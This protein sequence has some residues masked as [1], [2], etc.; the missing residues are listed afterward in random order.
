MKGLL[1]Y[2]PYIILLI[3]TL[4]RTVEN[5]TRKA[6]GEPCDCE[7]QRCICKYFSDCQMQ[8]DRDDIN[9]CNRKQGIV[10]CK[11]PK[12]IFDPPAQLASEF[13]CQKY[14]EMISNDCARE[15]ITGGELARAKEFPPAALVG[16]FNMETKKHDWICGGTLISERFVLTASH[17]AKTGV[18]NRVRLGDLDFS[19]NKDDEGVQEFSVSRLISHPQYDSSNYNDI[20]LLELNGTVTFTDYVQP[21]CLL[22]PSWTVYNTGVFWAVGWGAVD[23]STNMSPQ[24]RRV[25]LRKLENC[26]PIANEAYNLLHGLSERTQFCTH[27]KTNDTCKGDSG[28]PLLITFPSKEEKYKCLYMVAGIISKGQIECSGQDVP[29]LHTNV[30]AFVRFIEYHV[31]P[32]KNNKS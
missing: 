12:I 9:Y 15:F 4:S 20:M 27:G 28:G 6:V 25:Q 26:G 10:C 24:L 14:T 8:Y 30:T 16:R 1:K 17:C 18:I 2:L 13:A 3:F 11:E 23:H 31:W 29:S 7:S 21:A 5:K 32:T 19:S 22:T